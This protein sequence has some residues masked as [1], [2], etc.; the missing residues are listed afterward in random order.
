MKTRHKK[1]ATLVILLVVVLAFFY[2]DGP[3]A[4]SLHHLKSTQE[5]WRLYYLDH[6]ILLLSLFF[7]LYVTV[8]A[9]SLP[10]AT[11]LGLAAGAIFDFKVGV[12]IVSFAS[13]MGATL[14]CALSRFLFSDWL[15]NKWGSHLKNMNQGFAKDGALY[16][17]SL[18]LMPAVPFF[19][20]NA[21]MGLTPIPLFTFYWVS[22]ISMLPG[23]MVYVNAG[24]QLAQ[25]ESIHGL[26]SLRVIGSLT[27]LGLLPLLGRHL[28]A[29]IQRRSR[30]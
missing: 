25:I 9:L 15:K 12:V 13:T 28:N 11:V 3:E 5:F 29:L 2:L 4:L 27:L 1:T 10:G 19:V 24:T 14:A 6:P 7:A 16:L 21:G 26:M 20:I 18:R 8:T 17:F 30:S 23:T 22:Q